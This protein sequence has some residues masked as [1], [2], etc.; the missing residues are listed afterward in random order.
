A[1]NIRKKIEEIKF[2][3]AGND[4]ITVSIGV[5]ENPIDGANAEEIL[6]KARQYVARARGEGKNKVIGE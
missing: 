2:S 4:R 1:E 3:D 5:G 6:A